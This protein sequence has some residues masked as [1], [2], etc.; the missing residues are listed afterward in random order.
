MPNAL[1]EELHK[2]KVEW[3]ATGNREAAERVMKMIPDLLMSFRRLE[4]MLTKSEAAFNELSDSIKEQQES[5]KAEEEAPENPKKMR[6]PRRVS[7]V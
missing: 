7:K 3:D 6:S 2:A 4:G 5:Q 1:Y